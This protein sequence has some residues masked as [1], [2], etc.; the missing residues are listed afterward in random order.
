V[1]PET[2]VVGG[3]VDEASAAAVDDEG[4]GQSTLGEQDSWGTA[5]QRGDR[6][7]PPGLFQQFGGGPDV[8]RRAD[9]IAGVA[10]AAEA[11]ARLEVF[12]LMRA[13]L[14]DVM[15]EPAGRQYHAPS[16]PHCHL[17]AVLLQHSA[18]DTV[19]VDDQV[20]Q[21]GPRPHRDS[22]A[23]HPGVQ[24]GGQGLSAG[25]ILAADQFASETLHHALCDTRDADAGQAGNQVHPP[26]VGAGDRHWHGRSHGGGAQPGPF[27][28]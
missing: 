15:V 9:G 19:T 13:A 7:E 4:A 8:L 18:R 10:R 14:L 20:T 3:L 11:P 24:A 21:S 25:G 27:L 17:V 6:R 26:V 2:H 28:A 1:L 22:G 16:C 12:G 5:G 23:Q